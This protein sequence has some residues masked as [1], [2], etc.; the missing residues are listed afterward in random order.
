MIAAMVKSCARQGS[1]LPTISDVGF[2]VPNWRYSDGASN[3]TPD[4]I[5]TVV[6]RAAE[7]ERRTRTTMNSLN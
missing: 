2:I 4:E 5:L 7:E 1:A 3:T 6:E